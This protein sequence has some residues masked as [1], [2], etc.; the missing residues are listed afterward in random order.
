MNET[1][2][3]ISLDSFRDGLNA[4]VIGSS[5]GIG[6]AFVNHL[7]ACDAVASIQAFARSDVTIQQ[8]KVVSGRVHLEDEASIVAAANQAKDRVGELD[9]VIVA[10]GLLHEDG[11]HPEKTWRSLEADSLSRAYAINTIGPALVAKH[12]LP[13]L[14]R[15]SKALFAALSARIGSISDN[16]FGGWHSYRASK[17]AL[18]MLIRNFAI[19]LARHNPAALC[20][21]LHPG[22]VDSRLSRP[23]QRNVPEGKLFSPEFATYRMLSVMNG[24]KPDDSGRIFAWD[25]AEIAP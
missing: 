8:S 25:G 1:A 15:E 17:A 6:R 23:F 12:F 14:S 20:I 9:L 13:L 24:L 2:F 11:M 19:E 21:G 22:T 4:A 16:E 7:A 18:N 10:T 3:D 5:G